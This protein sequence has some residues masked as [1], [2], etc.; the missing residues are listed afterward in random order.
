MGEPIVVLF[1]VLALLGIAL[2]VFGTLRHAGSIVVAGSALL[3]AIVGAWVLGLYG[4]A[5]GLVALGLL[6]RRPRA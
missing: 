1:A 2:V 6:R 3:I 5:T 4:A